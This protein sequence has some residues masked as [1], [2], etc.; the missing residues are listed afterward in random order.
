[1]MTF[2]I[3]FKQNLEKMAVFF[4]NPL[5]VP[6]PAGGGNVILLLSYNYKNS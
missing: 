2:F 3:L 6:P 4:D 1:M 5:P